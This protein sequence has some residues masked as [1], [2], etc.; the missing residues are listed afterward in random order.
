[1]PKRTLLRDLLWVTAVKL[2]ALA[3]IYFLF[4]A[5]PAQIDA[6]HHLLIDASAIAP[7][8]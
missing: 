8:R 1:M 7:S 3:A 2:V 4:F 6:A 5:S